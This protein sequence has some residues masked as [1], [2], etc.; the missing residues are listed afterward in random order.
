M[1]TTQA[2]PVNRAFRDLVPASLRRSWAADGRYQ[3]LDL[4]TLF[5]RHARRCPDRAAV[6]DADGEIGYAQ[7][8]VLVRRLAAG[9]TALD[10][11]AGD[12][13]AVQL[14]NSRLSCALDF[15]IAAVGGIVLPFPIGRGERDIA[16]LLGRSRAV[17]AVTASS[18][19][20][21]PCG[22]RTFDLVGALPDLR[23]VITVGGATPP[24]CVP[25]SLLLAADHSDFTPVRPDPDSAARILVSSGSEAEPKMVVYSHNALAGGRGRF[26]Q[27]ISGGEDYRALF[28][29]PL[30]TAFGSNATPATMAANGGTMLVQPRFDVT[31]TL[32]M[33][34]R[35]RPT[36]VFGVPTMFRK[37]I[38]SPDLAATDLSSVRAV[39][40]GGSALDPE[41]AR[42]VSTKL[43][44]T[45][46]NVYGSADGVNCHT[47]FTDPPAKVGTAGRPNPVVCE[48]RVV[49][50]ALD[51]VPDGHTG[52]VIARGPMSPMS[53]LA[54]PELDA[55]Y[56]L[57]GGWVRLG[58]V[59]RIDADGYLTVV[60]RRKD[61][62]I[63]GGMNISPAEVEALLLTHEDVDDVACVAIPDPVFGDRMCACVATGTEL[64]LVE[65]TDH[66]TGQ[67]LE[68][69]RLPERLLLLPALPLGA[70]GKVDRKALTELAVRL[71]AP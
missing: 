59:G 69:R 16:S 61:V 63:R 47:T 32:T 34:E 44:A 20:D 39:V 26:I 7:F 37:I 57:D 45:V 40:L 68:P 60:G 71:A 15:A 54:A 64:S 4:Y 30:G 43:T 35:A 51:P 9:L 46:I 65:L 56:R 66:L 58:D 29:M 6:V 50:D 62:I 25:M 11:C 53:Y 19:G 23:S 13:V 27:A 52:E 3:D 10:V 38:D 48:I 17:V 31:S 2:L 41:T 12:V 70:A 22:Q 55:R 49:D 14:P 24:G 21:F 67:G 33:I 5:E 8:D 28:L 36:H 1:T 42:H 18:Y